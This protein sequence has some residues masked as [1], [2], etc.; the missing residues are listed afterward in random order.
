MILLFGLVLSIV[1]VFR[2]QTWIGVGE[3]AVFDDCEIAGL[4]EKV[5]GVV[6][7]NGSRLNKEE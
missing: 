7:E 6:Y 4:D 3:C 1:R 2:I 5:A